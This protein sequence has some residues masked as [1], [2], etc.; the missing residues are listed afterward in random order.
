MSVASSIFKTFDIRGLYKKE[1][2]PQTT[3]K[4]AK[5]YYKEFNPKKIVLGYD[6]REGSKPLAEVFMNTLMSLG[7][8]VVDIGLVSTPRL[9]YASHKYSLPYGVM[10]T[11]SH[12][13]KEYT[14]VKFTV[15][16]LPPSEDK[17]V[18]LKNLFIKEDSSAPVSAKEKG[19]YEKK[20]ISN[21]YIQDILSFHTYSF[22]P[23]K[24]IID[25]GNSVN[26]PIVDKIFIPSLG[27][28]EVQFI[29]KKV[30]SSF[31]SHGLNPKIEKNQ[32]PLSEKIKKEKADLGVLWDGD[33][34][35]VYF[36]DSSGKS[37]SPQFVSA[38]VASYMVSTD[39]KSRKTVTADIRAGRVIEEFVKKVGGKVK[40]IKAWHTE[41][42]FA[43]QEDADIIFGSETSGH[44][45]FRDFFM[46]DDGLLMSLMF[47]QAVSYHKESLEQL[48]STLR[49][50]Y[51][52]PEEVNFKVPNVQEILSQVLY[53]YKSKG[54]V[55]LI[56]GVTIK[57]KDWRFNIRPSRTEPLLRLNF[58]GLNLPQV[59]TEYKNLIDFLIQ[60]KGEVSK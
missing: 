28:K 47:L 13:P 20:D 33:A 44:Y 18:T 52:I 7:V 42:K 22:K 8:D 29:F 54:E 53:K 57:A 39:P 49:R 9:Y 4:L 30:D 37:I 45:V 14:G 12:N 51:F 35:R 17:L 10:F 2:N 59:K 11:A 16:A 41:I 50:V 25:C 3:V 5:A 60:N 38:I 48:L 26:A 23:L 19:T 31:P 24:V 56:D 40:T 6:A 43:M 15:N 21:D 32:K 46:I 27:L 36:L 55:I 1:L 58:S 34:D